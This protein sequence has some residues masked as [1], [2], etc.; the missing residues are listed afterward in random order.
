MLAK[1]L[2]WFW[3]VTGVLFLVRPDFLR[4][5]IHKK[6]IKVVRRYL[7]AILLFFAAMLITTGFKYEGLVAKIL[8]VMGIVAIFKGFFLLK[9]KAADKILQFLVKQPLFTFRLWALAQIG[10]GYIVLNIK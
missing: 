4:K 10:L 7:F 6:S 9:A 2:G 3:V 8:L 1:I 5:R